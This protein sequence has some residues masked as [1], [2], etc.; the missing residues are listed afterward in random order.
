MKQTLLIFL[1]FEK[2]FLKIWNLLSL[3]SFANSCVKMLSLANK[4]GQI[5]AVNAC[6]SAVTISEPYS[7]QALVLKNFLIYGN[8]FLV[9]KFV[10]DQFAVIGDVA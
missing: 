3:N 1:Q 9:V 7:V 8:Y 10:T 5:I 2:N 4:T 6:V